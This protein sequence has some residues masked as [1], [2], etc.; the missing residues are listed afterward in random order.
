MRARVLALCV[1]GLGGCA[2]R[3]PSRAP[4][5]GAHGPPLLAWVEGEDAALAL[6]VM[7][8]TGVRGPIAVEVRGAAGVGRRWMTRGGRMALS[9]L[10]ARGPLEIEVTWT[11]PGDVAGARVVLH[12]PPRRETAPPRAF[13]PIERVILGRDGPS[14]EEA[15]RIR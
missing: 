9:E 6:T 1:A 7:P 14:V 8:V 12:H 13:E 3:A 15:I 4:F 2:A 10:A 5:Q 11:D